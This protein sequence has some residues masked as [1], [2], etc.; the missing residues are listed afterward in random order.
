MKKIIPF[1]PKDQLEELE[2]GT[3]EIIPRELFLKKLNASYKNQIPLK[4]KFGADPSS[5]DIH[6]GHT[7]IL[8]KLR[9]FQD[10]GHSIYFLIGDFTSQIGDPTGRI[11]TRPQ[12]KMK[13][14]KKNSI[15]YRDQVKKIL[16][17]KKTKI[18]YNSEWWNLINAN[19]FIQ[20]LSK[21]TVQMISKRE[22]FSERFKKEQ[23]LYMHEFIYPLVQAYDSYALKSDIEVGGTDQ[24]FNMLMGRDLQKAYSQEEETHTHSLKDSQK[25]PQKKRFKF[26]KEPLKEPQ[27]VLTL[28]LLEGLDGVNKMSKSLGNAISINDE[29]KNIFGKIMSLSDHLMI[30]Y[31]NLVSRKEKKTIEKILKAIK[32]KT[33]HPMEAKKDLAQE[34]TSHYYSKERAQEERIRFENQFSK[35]K[36]PHDV[37]IVKKSSGTLSIISFLKDDLQWFQSNGE[38][39][40]ILKQNGI[41]VNGKFLNKEQFPL[42]SCKSYLIKAGKLRIVKIIVK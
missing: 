24:T 26:E 10:F 18:V 35:R 42:E 5:P 25:K 30:R 19:K 1:T 31:Y 11:K 37:K 13:E 21:T 12:L 22:D 20:I 28:P 16:D 36:T 2:R 32:E 29:A 7:I 15:T 39:R 40:R 8:Q 41:K 34:I 14:V 33:L 9:Q 6:I 27:V 17:I 3:Q 4:I 38:V 23:P